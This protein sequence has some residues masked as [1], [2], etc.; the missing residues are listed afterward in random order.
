LKMAATPVGVRNIARGSY[1]R[2]GGGF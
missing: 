2:F 1:R